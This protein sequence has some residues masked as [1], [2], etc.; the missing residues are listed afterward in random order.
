V[1]SKINIPILRSFLTEEWDKLLPRILAQTWLGTIYS[2]KVLFKSSSRS[3][4][5][6]HSSSKRTVFETGCMPTWLRFFFR[7]ATSAVLRFILL[8]MFT[9]RVILNILQRIWTTIIYFIVWIHITLR[10]KVSLFNTPKFIP[11][12]FSPRALRCRILT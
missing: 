4:V 2:L 6:E 5:L 10:Q 12:S 1:N 3:V 7:S 9:F 8:R 11:R